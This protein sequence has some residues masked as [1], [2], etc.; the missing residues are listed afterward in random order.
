[1]LGLRLHEENMKIIGELRRKSYN[2]SKNQ[3]R[4]KERENDKD[5]SA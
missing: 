2:K 4:L 3:S 5:L 1:M